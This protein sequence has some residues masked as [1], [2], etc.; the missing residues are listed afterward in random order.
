MGN[1]G[2]CLFS[3]SC[4]QQVR[5]TIVGTL[6]IEELAQRA[7][8]A[9]KKDSLDEARRNAEEAVALSREIGPQQK[10]VRALMLLGQIERDSDHR[11]AALQHYKEAVDISRNV[12]QPLRFA[13]TLRHLADLYCDDGMLD[14]AES[15]YHEVLATYRTNKG[16][17]PGDLANAIRGFAVMKDAAGSPDEARPLWEEARDLYASLGVEEGV[18][19]CNSRLGE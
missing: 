19:E 8:L 15:C 10:L 4:Y 12:D 5:Q 17:S 18:Q 1:L 16:S 2:Y 13:H 6:T 14:L 11:T 3:R 7:A 9:R